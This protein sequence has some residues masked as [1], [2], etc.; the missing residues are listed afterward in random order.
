MSGAY[1]PPPESGPPGFPPPPQGGP[2]GFPPPQSGPPGFPPYSPYGY[3]PGP[4]RSHYPLDLGRILELT[5]SIFRYRWQTFVGIALL[6]MIPAWIVLSISTALLYT[7]TDWYTVMTD[8]FRTGQFE[9]PLPRL[10]PAL[11]AN[12]VISALVGIATS[13]AVGALTD[14]A[15]TTYAGGTPSASASV[16][17]S[18]GRLLTYTGVFLLTLA[19]SFVIVFIGVLIGLALFFATVSDGRIQPGP[20]VF[21]GLIVFVATFVALV[22]IAIRFAFAVPV[23][24]VESV[25]ALDAL[26]RSWRLVS[27]SSWRVLGYLI[28]FALLVGVVGAILSTVINIVVSPIRPTSLTTFEIDP[29]RLGISTFITG[30]I[31]SALMPLPAIGTAL[32]YFDLRWR[33]GEPVPHGG[34]EASAAP[35]GQPPLMPPDQPPNQPPPPGWPQ[36]PRG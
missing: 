5:F 13:V 11:L 1:P 22:F 21:F 23:V 20:F 33:R 14:A 25:G 15:A 3:Q 28:V 7:S 24:V 8:Q 2:P 16:R 32:L 26:R 4:P 30:L 29:T 9:N 27:G 18:L 31:T 34:A 35:P 36:P 12:F 17:R 10:W 19:I 6:I